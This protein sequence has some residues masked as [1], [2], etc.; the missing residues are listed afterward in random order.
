MGLI[1]VKA[2]EL[3]IGTFI[4]LSGSWFEHPFPTNSFKIKS[5][6]E[7]S[8]LRG[9]R[10][11]QIFIDS[12]RSDPPPQMEEELD[13]KSSQQ[14]TREDSQVES[15]EPEQAPTLTAEQA[16]IERRK[17]L[18]QAEEDYKHV[19]NGTKT[20][21]REIK[22]GYVRGIT[23][24]ET[25]V[26]QIDDMLKGDGTIVALMNLMG[27]KEVGGEFYYHS[28]Y[29]HSLNVSILSIA[30]G[31]E[32]DLP[33]EDVNNMG[34]GGLLHD[35]GYL[36]GLNQ[37]TTKRSLQNKEELRTI[38]RHPINGQLMV[39]KGFGL[40]PDALAII[41]EHHERLNG[42]GFPKGL[43]NEA[44]HPLAKIVGIVDAFDELCNNPDLQ[45]SLTPYEALAR[46]Y[47][48]RKVEFMEKPVEALIGTLGVFPP[49]SLVEL[50]DGRIGVICTINLND[51]MRP[52]VLLYS[53]Q[54]PRT[55]APILDLAKEAPTLTLK[56]GLR[57]IQVPPKIWEYLNSRG[58]ISFFAT[59]SKKD[60]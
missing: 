16:K 18:I 2:E 57:P 37:F 58:M 23:Q 51:R 19:V 30:I 53:E 20:L 52:Q 35:I 49:S 15:Q 10:K 1:S 8:I 46:L 26:D 39:D 38:N 3:H 42:S 22:N 5:E 56:Q 47:R 7:L 13:P 40:S 9:L 50:S 29:Y 34:I 45:E 21:I 31:R 43:K 28:L 17:V 27:P 32:L 54:H 12:D 48:K 24:A 36:S 33:E 4:K 11:T 55:D 60:Q 44:I 41:S 6:K 14:S 59:P 25:L